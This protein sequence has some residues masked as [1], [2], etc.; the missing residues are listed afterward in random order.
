MERKAHE[1]ELAHEIDEHGPGQINRLQG[2]EE[3]TAFPWWE[4]GTT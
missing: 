2:S 3:E 4:S 1:D